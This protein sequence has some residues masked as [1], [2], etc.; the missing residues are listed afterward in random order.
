MQRRR[1]A[2]GL[3]SALAMVSLSTGGIASAHGNDGDGEAVTWT[4]SWE[5]CSMVPHGTVVE[6]TGEID[7]GFSTTTRRGITTERFDDR[8]EGTATDQDGNTYTWTYRNT[9]TVK[10]TAGEPDV[11]SG[12]MADRFRLSG[13]GPIKLSNGFRA[14]Y[15]EDRSTDPWTWGIYPR[16][17]YGDPFN[18]PTGPNR[19]DPL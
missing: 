13:D 15:V 2:V 16:S 1:V 17:S 5:N 10:N 6:G 8:A 9:L 14:D 18:F 7:R 19:C 11:F 12:R 3:V 4:L